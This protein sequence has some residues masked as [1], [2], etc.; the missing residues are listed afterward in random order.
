MRLLKSSMLAL[1]VLGFAG[2]HESAIQQTTQTSTLRKIDIDIRTGDDF[3][4]LLKFQYGINI[5]EEQR[6]SIKESWKRID[7][8]EKAFLA[9]TYQN[10]FSLIDSF[11][12]E[13]LE[14]YTSA[15]PDTL[16]DK[17][18]Q[19]FLKYYPWMDFKNPSKLD[20]TKNPF[21]YQRRIADKIIIIHEKTLEAIAE[22]GILAFP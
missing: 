2:C 13:D 15:N 9:K 12:K 22:S 16:S 17:E 18:K 7:P 1:A 6:Q 5:S 3:L 19:D 21:Q 4:Y 10:P 11:D 8:S 14:F 20:K